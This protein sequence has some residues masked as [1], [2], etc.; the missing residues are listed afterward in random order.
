MATI[1]VTN[2]TTSDVYVADLYCTVPASKAISTSRAMTDM[3]RMAGLMSLIAAGTVS[4]SLAMTADEKA[5]GLVDAEIASVS[6]TGGVA[7]QIVVR[8][9]LA[10][11][12]GGSAD[13]VTIYA[14]NSLPFKKMRVLDAYA[15]VSAGA[16][17]GRTIKVYTQA[18]AAGTQVA[19]MGAAANGRQAQD[20][21]I[22]ATS[23]ITSGA[24]VGLF[25][26]RS[27]SAIAGEV[28]LTLRSEV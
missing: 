17:G 27:D 1:T 9:A 4:I 21:T 14:L 10:A 20:T 16:S 13:D 11:G 8:T 24:S 26:R 25:A 22:T 23:V 6:N 7:D 12:G 28:I 3:S 15:Y 19:S 2:L 5:S 18:A